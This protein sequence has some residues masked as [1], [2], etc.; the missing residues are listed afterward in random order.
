[1]LSHLTRKPLTTEDVWRLCF[2]ILSL[3]LCA[4]TLFMAILLGTKAYPGTIATLMI[5]TAFS[6]G[7]SAH[8]EKIQPRIFFPSSLILYVCACIVMAEAIFP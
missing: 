3:V 8:L 5:A 4:V 2:E 1:M 7:V 6:W